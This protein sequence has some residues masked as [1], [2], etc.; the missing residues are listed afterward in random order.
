MMMVFDVTS[1]QRVNRDVSHT[2]HLIPRFL[3]PLSQR[4]VS[5]SSWQVLSGTQLCAPPE[6]RAAPQAPLS[7]LGAREEES[8][9]GSAIPPLLPFLWGPV[10]VSQSMSLLTV[11]VSSARLLNPRKGRKH[12]AGRLPEGLLQELSEAPLGWEGWRRRR[13][14]VYAPRSTSANS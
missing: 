3:K 4:A 12:G 13:T 8:W 10:P 1:Y 9:P 2:D 7:L 5:A 6:A 11:P 14:C